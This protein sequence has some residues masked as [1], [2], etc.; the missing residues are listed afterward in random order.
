MSGPLPAETTGTRA[1]P[2]HV[3]ILL[4]A[5]QVASRE[6]IFLATAELLAQRGYRVTVLA[7]RPNDELRARVQAPLLLR[8]IDPTATVPGLRH[9]PHVVRLY[10]S[11]PVVAKFLRQARPDVLFSTSI[12]P[13]MVALGARLLSRQNTRIVIRQSNVVRARGHA[14]SAGVARRPRDW[15][16]PLLYPKAD[17]IIAVSQGVAENLSAIPSIDPSRIHAVANAVAIDEAAEKAR[18]P[19]DHPWFRPGGPPVLL[20]A[21]RLIRK[22]DYATM[23]RALARVRAHV[24]ARLIVLGE[25]PERPALE[26]LIASLGL[27]DCVDLLGYRPNPFAFMAR[28]SLFVMSSRFEG[29]P[30]VLIEALACGC[31]LVSTDCPSGPAEILDQGRFGTLVPMG[32]VER[33]ADAILQALR[34]PPDRE[35]LVA[36]ARDFARQGAAER[37][38]EILTGCLAAADAEAGHGLGR[39]AVALTR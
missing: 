26:R 32:D 20:A 24:D 33:L 23:L 27:G 7:A 37:Y 36:R 22:K 13:N 34:T 14:A 2:G 19:V 38:V 25:G 4:S 11:L 28:A 17:A 30:S 18:E 21:G 10:C 5:S 12:P 29:M 16:M 15:L 1:T 6:R 8:D 35:R 3:A 31:P 9:L 39:S